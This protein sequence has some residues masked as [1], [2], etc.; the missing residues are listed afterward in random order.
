MIN[1]VYWVL[2]ALFCVRVVKVVL[3]LLYYLLYILPFSMKKR[4]GISKDTIESI[5][6]YILANVVRGLVCFLYFYVFYLTGT[7][8]SFNPLNN[9]SWIV[10]LFIFSYYFDYF[11][12][13][14]ELD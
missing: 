10:F 5:Q 3:G 11:F 6:S 13:G 4:H 14:N 8:R 2:L 9:I 7:S 12:V 1:I